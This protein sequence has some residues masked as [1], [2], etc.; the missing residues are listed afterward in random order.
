[1]GTAGA[2]SLAGDPSN[3]TS[4]MAE[5]GGASGGNLNT[6]GSAT[7]RDGGKAVTG[8]GAGAAGGYSNVSPTRDGGTGGS[9]GGPATTSVRGGGGTAG[10][11]GPGVGGNGG[12]GADGDETRS[13]AG[14]GAG[15]ATTGGSTA[16]TAGD[17]GNGGFPSGGGGGAGGGSSLA[18][19]T[20]TTLQPAPP[21]ALCDQPDCKEPAV[22]AFTWEWGVTGVCCEKH[23]FVLNQTAGNIARSITFSPLNASASPPLQRE[24]RVRLKAE[25]LTLQ[26]ELTEAKTRG[27]EL[28]RQNTL[29]TQQVQALTVRGRTTE[30]ERK[31]AITEQSRM[32]ARLEELEAENA[33]LADELQRL[34][35]LVDIPPPAEETQ[36]GVGPTA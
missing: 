34:R 14:G 26:E 35:V 1:M 11:A 8:G 5:D 24:E 15:G 19:T 4:N 18:P 17:G 20:T 32:S 7:A 12:N 29:L 36:P 16:Y 30:A 3:P 9:S 27:L 23:R 22:Y 10:L 31:D 28:Y 13:G 6:F 2:G 33:T 21:I 25:I